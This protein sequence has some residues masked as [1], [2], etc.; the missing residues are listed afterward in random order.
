MAI[1]VMRLGK[2]REKQKQEMMEV[3]CVFIDPSTPPPA[4]QLGAP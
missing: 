4:G 1:A 3:G 2:R